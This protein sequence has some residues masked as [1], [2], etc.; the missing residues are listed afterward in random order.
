MARL[1]PARPRFSNVTEEQALLVLE[2]ELDDTFV[3]FQHRPCEGFLVVHPDN[4]FCLVT[5]HSGVRTFDADA[6]GWDGV[7]I[8]AIRRTGTASLAQAG[9]PLGAELPVLAFLPETI[10]AEGRADRA[11]ILSEQASS[12]SM[13]VRMAMAGQPGEAAI[14]GLIQ[15]LSP[16]AMGYRRGSVTEPQIRWREQT[17][18]YETSA[19][20]LTPAYP[21]PHASF[22][23]AF[24]VPPEEKPSVFA[25]LSPSNEAVLATSPFPPPASFGSAFAPQPFS[26]PM[27]SVEPSMPALMLPDI[28]KDDPLMLLM[29]QTL[30]TVVSGRPVFVAGVRVNVF[31]MVKL[32]FLLPAIL[33][34]A[35]LA[36]AP[37]VSSR[38]GKGGFYIRLRTDRKALLGYRV[39]GVNPA[40]PLLLMVPV[41]DRVRRMLQNEE[42]Y[43]DG[44]ILQ[45][46]RWLAENRYNTDAL[47]DYDVRMSLDMPVDSEDGGS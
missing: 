43:L 42:F 47:A 29:Q 3:I 20:P 10:L 2:R 15:S 27:I 1:V 39:V 31:D 22:G 12:L 4:G 38:S 11:I 5:I 32:D 40:T 16:G 13:L 45:F 41:V 33:V 14:S 9:C 18:G 19:S 36:W 23:S 17:G 28:A 46:H 35:G 26:G 34:S 7:D 30:E 8:E 25:G 37:V 21:P 6:E 44:L 24:D